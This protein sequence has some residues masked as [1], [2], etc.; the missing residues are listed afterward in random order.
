[1][2]VVANRQPA[3]VR[4]DGVRPPPAPG[5]LRQPLGRVSCNLLVAFSRGVASV[6]LSRTRAKRPRTAKLAAHSL[7]SCASA[8]VKCAIEIR[9]YL[10]SSLYGDQEPTEPSA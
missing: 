6:R 3:A 4:H 10:T 8:L 1:M 7:L 2:M 5:Q 9:V